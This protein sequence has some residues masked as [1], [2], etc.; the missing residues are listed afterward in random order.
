MNEQHEQREPDV[1]DKAFAQLDH[2]LDIVHDRVLRPIFI[3]GRAVAFGFIIVLMAIVLVA[4][5]LIA[6]IRLFDVYVFSSHQWL[7]YVC[8][9]ATFV[10]AGLVFWRYRRSDHAGD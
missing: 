5:L 4:A 9:G 2:A 3:A 1:V 8:I 7:T 6:L 10:V